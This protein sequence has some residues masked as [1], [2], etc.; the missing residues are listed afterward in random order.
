MFGQIQLSV[1][2]WDENYV[3]LICGISEQPNHPPPVGI[4]SEKKESHI[5]GV[6][7]RLMLTITFTKKAIPLCIT[8]SPENSNV[9]LQ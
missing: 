7:K 4:T 6:N 9:R 5:I 3:Y 8:R 2:L 1:I